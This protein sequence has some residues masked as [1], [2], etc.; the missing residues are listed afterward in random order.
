MDLNALDA[1]LFFQINQSTNGVFDILM[2]FL[3][4]KGYLLALPFGAFIIWQ[5][6][7]QPA[8][9]RRETLHLAIWTIALAVI[10]FLLADWMSNE[11][12]QVINR[13]RPCHALEGVRLLGGCT[14][15]TS[16][17]SGHS[18][19]SFAY[20]VPL[21]F[22]TRNYIKFAWR[23]Y[24]L[25]LAA[26]VAYSRPY[27]GVHYPGDIA[28][29]ALLGTLCAAATIALFTFARLRY[30]KRPRVTLML[31]SLVVITI[32]RIFY[33]LRGPLDLSPVEAWYWQLSAGIAAAGQGASPLLTVLIGMSTSLLGGTVFGIR[34]LA[35]L[36][37]LLSSYIIFRLVVD[38]YGDEA[39]ALGSALLLQAIPLFSFLG[40]FMTP[41]SPLVF[42]WSISLWM[43]YR[44]VTRQQVNQSVLPAGWILLGISVGLGVLIDGSMIL[45]P[46]GMMVFLSISDGRGQLKT[47]KPYASIL[48]SLCCVLL[49]GAVKGWA[50]IGI[51][52]GQ[53]PGG[54]GTDLSTSGILRFV[55]W[56]AGM[57]T[58]I[59]LVVIFI[60]LHKL[61]YKDR[62]LQSSYLFAFSIP[63]LAVSLAANLFINNRIDWTITGYITGIIAAAFCL[64]R[65]REASDQVSAGKDYRGYLVYTGLLL[66]IIATAILH[67]SA[68]IKL[69]PYLDP[70]YEMK[71]W[72]ALGTE[73]SAVY[74]QQKK[75]GPVIISSDSCAVSGELA[76]YVK[77]HPKTYCESMMNRYAE[78][79]DS[80]I[81]VMEG[82]TML[83]LSLNKSFERF[84]KKV[85]A[86]S[87][88]KRVIKAYSIFICYNFSG[89]ETA[90]TDR[91]QEQ[92]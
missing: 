53:F 27:L 88:K 55:A 8:D 90:L 91:K 86:I 19:N 92:R 52:A 43:L 2:P 85:C 35:L 12:K 29:G 11:L 78:K 15:S 10:S 5:A 54:F 59:I 36:F 67:F 63:I 33:I 73:V 4:N 75:S 13:L 87:Q 77:G 61:F 65:P 26:A 9:K 34:I 70:T 18:T 28:A 51:F 48:I 42:F 14:Q 3:S 56:Q 71:G 50:G 79:G 37:S 23:L 58:P 16:M 64:L 7:K 74:E 62:G 46:L 89:P 38:M 69:P 72:R 68:A 20:A 84:D 66:S 49:W 44:V 31:G 30:A 82:D 39:A 45:F 83:P 81:Y 41:D 32:F 1:K 57:M 6:L 22:M 17:P 25:I 40:L 21:F 24:P 47:I 80:V 76:Y 60:S